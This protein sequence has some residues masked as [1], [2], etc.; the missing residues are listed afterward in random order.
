MAQAILMECLY[1]LISLIN[2]ATSYPDLF[3]NA[4]KIAIIIPHLDHVQNAQLIMGPSI[5]SYCLI[6]LAKVANSVQI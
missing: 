3:S 6:L 1:F 5:P 2:S 4:N